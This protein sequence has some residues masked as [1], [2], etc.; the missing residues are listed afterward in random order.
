MIK[1]S[2]PS[3]R[4][5]V[6]LAVLALAGCV[7]VPVQFQGEFSPLT[8]Q[9]AQATDADTLVRWGGVILETRPDERQT[10]FE[11]LSRP[12]RS[13]MRPEDS[14]QTLGRFI[15]C[16]E[17]FHDPEVFAR[18]RE[19][20]LTGTIERIDIRKVGEFD[21]H[22][23]VVRAGFMSMWPERQEVIVYEYDGFYA[24]YYWHYPYRYPYP[25]PYHYPHPRTRDKGPR[26]DLPPDS[27]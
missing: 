6:M 14:D 21:Y 17:G 13:S 12:L 16:K 25:Y 24:P 18:G 4:A 26:I 23:P 15:G 2:Q 1:T 5:T 11:I 27:G 3:F 9:A 19:V 22:Y 10:C 7:S 8:P 20:T